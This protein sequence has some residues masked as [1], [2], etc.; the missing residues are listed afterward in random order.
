MRQILEMLLKFKNIPGALIDEI[1]DA[2]VDEYR[3]E[4]VKWAEE[5]PDNATPVLYAARRLLRDLMQK[6]VKP[7][8]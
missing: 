8:T 7:L 2:I 3:E 5:C 1:A 4:L 6:I